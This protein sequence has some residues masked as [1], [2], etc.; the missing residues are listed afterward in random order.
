MVATL[1]NPTA[2][3][4]IAALLLVVSVKP[5]S[6]DSVAPLLMFNFWGFVLLFGNWDCKLLS[7]K[8][9]KLKNAPVRGRVVVGGCKALY[10]GCNEV[11]CERS[12]V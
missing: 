9:D 7:S 3:I 1:I 8:K 4:L 12:N 10:T 11:R 2:L 5:I 6:G